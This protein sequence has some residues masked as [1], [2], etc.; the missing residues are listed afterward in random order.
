MI[1]LIITFSYLNCW[2]F[3]LGC[4]KP[5]KKL[6]HIMIYTICIFRIRYDTE[7]SFQPQ[8]VLNSYVELLV[9]VFYSGESK[10]F[11]IFIFLYLKITLKHSTVHRC[12]I[13]VSNFY[14]NDNCF[15]FDDQQ[16]GKNVIPKECLNINSNLNMNNCIYNFL[17]KSL[18]MPS[19]CEKNNATVD[20]L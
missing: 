17:L 8:Y 12:G 16:M 5:F 10:A 3:Q 14:T 18:F 15:S 19:L 9:V 1:C 4:N 7:N 20:K 2:L 6:Q 11:L 13:K